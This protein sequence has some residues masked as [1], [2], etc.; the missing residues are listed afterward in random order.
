MVKQAKEAESNP[1]GIQALAE[2]MKGIIDAVREQGVAL[3]SISGRFD[4]LEADMNEIKKGSVEPT[5][6]D[7]PVDV[8]ADVRALA[9]LD[10]SAAMPVAQEGAV[11]PTTPPEVITQVQTDEAPVES[12]QGLHNAVV[13]T[14]K[15]G[16]KKAKKIVKLAVAHGSAG[17]RAYMTPGGATIGGIHCGGTVG[18]SPAHR[19]ATALLSACEAN[20]GSFPKGSKAPRKVR[21][22]KG[23]ARK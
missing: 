13:G 19:Y 7:A 12:L 1:K 4:D 3:S 16:A 14:G 9:G 18:N 22:D 10:E 8:F 21:S 5:A 6:Q 20:G 11:A 2:G 15:N 23:L 17:M